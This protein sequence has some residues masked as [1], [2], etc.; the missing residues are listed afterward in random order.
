M[1][2]AYLH[3]FNHSLA[4]FTV[5]KDDTGQGDGAVILC[6]TP[7]TG[8]MERWGGLPKYPVNLWQRQQS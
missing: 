7:L 5:T 8:S 6:F 3:E 4:V 1:L 2:G